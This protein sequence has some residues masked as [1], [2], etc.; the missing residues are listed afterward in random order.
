MRNPIHTGDRPIAGRR[1]GRESAATPAVP[2]TPSSRL[3]GAVAAPQAAELANAEG[4]LL[5]Q[6]W[7][8][9]ARA[10]KREATTRIEGDPAGGFAP[11]REVITPHLEVGNF[12]QTQVRRPP[13]AG[14]PAG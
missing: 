10:H 11:W 5:R 3:L 14:V 6:K 4:D 1:G 9:H 13:A 2:W 8:E 7:G 12:V